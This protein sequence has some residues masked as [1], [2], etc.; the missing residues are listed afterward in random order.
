VRL[1]YSKVPFKR[2]VQDRNRL[3]YF[4][5]KLACRRAEKHSF[6]TPTLE[7]HIC[8]V[9]LRTQAQIFRDSETGF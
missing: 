2:E 6:P 3:L 1:S 8:R 9:C 7:W 4:H 5:G